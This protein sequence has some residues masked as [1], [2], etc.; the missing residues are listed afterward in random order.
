MA[1]AR[2][3]Y[4]AAGHD[5]GRPPAADAS[6][7]RAFVWAHTLEADALWRAGDTAAAR[8][9]ADSVRWA[10]P[11]SYYGRDWAMPHH[12][13]ALLALSRHDSTSAE[14]ELEA[15]RWTVA[16]WT[17]TVLDLAALRLARGRADAAVATLRDAYRGPLDAMGRYVPRSELDWWMAQAFAR[18]GHPDSAAVYSSYARAAWAD[19]DPDVRRLLATLPR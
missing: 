15:G 6:S 11:R 13:A 3:L 14:R 2:A 4:E 12:L 5:A 19:A 8:V 10:A 7:A 17:R 18:A 16:G 1:E 9:L